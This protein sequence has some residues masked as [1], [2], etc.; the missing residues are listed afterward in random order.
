MWKFENNKLLC[1]SKGLLCKCTGTYRKYELSYNKELSLY[2]CKKYTQCSLTKQMLGIRL[3]KQNIAL[4]IFLNQGVMPQVLSYEEFVVMQLLPQNSKW[5]KQVE[6]KFSKDYTI[7]SAK[8]AVDSQLKILSS[9]MKVAQKNDVEKILNYFKKWKSPEEIKNRHGHGSDNILKHQGVNA[10]YKDIFKLIHDQ[11]AKLPS[12]IYIGSGKFTSVDEFIQ[13]CIVL[14]KNKT[15]STDGETLYY[16]YLLHCQRS[17]CQILKFPEFAN[18][19]SKLPECIRFNGK[20]F[21]GV[22]M[23]R[24]YSVKN[25]IDTGYDNIR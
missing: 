21:I 17:E 19:L 14:T 9:M 8:A 13:K 3:S 18:I 23:G 20:S 7:D 4:Q 24:E 6:N 2:C 25:Q 10:M 15:V 12:G 5:R 22:K 11:C 1:K 16:Q